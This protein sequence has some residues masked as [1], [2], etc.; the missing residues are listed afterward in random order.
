M[1]KIGFKKIP[2]FLVLLVCNIFVLILSIGALGAIFSSQFSTTDSLILLSIAFLLEVFGFWIKS[3]NRSNPLDFLKEKIMRVFAF[4]LAISVIGI[5]ALSAVLHIGENI[6][7]GNFDELAGDYHFSITTWERRE[8]AIEIAETLIFWENKSSF[9][10]KEEAEVVLH[11]FDLAKE[12][13][14]LL[15]KVDRKEAT[16]ED[17]AELNIIKEEMMIIQPIV[18][19]IIEKQLQEVLISEGISFIPTKIP[20]VSHFY[21][22]TSFK[23]ERPPSSLIIAQRDSLSEKARVYVRNDLNTREIEDLEKTTDELGYSSLVVRLGGISTYPSMVNPSS[24]H[25]AIEIIAHEWAHHYFM[26]TNLG[27]SNAPK[28]NNIE[29]TSAKIIGGELRDIIWERYY[30]SYIKTSENETTTT[31]AT[32]KINLAEELQKIRENV[33]DYLERGEVKKAEQYMNNRRDWLEENGHY[34][35]KLNQAYFVFYGYYATNPAHRAANDG[36]GEKLIDLRMKS[37]SL[38]KFILTVK[39]LETL[40]DL[41]RAL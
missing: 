27:R 3:E 13:K 34:I 10:A 30:E 4:F 29:E 6:V 19:N 1:K 36:I 14:S 18:E 16:R 7:L 37:S 25:R 26:F 9:T 32:D 8:A 23:I 12:E 28:Q 5:L 24:A 17:L 38:Q 41:N 22:G 20:L 2:Y 35:R 11:F 33:E 39:N 15:N 31:A 40:E 21:P